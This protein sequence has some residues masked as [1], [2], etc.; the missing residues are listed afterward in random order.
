MPAVRPFPEKHRETI[1]SLKKRLSE[2]LD[3][4]SE[5]SL[6]DLRTAIRRADASVSALPRTFRERRKT[7]RLSVKL[8]D[9]MRRSAKVRDLDT[10]RA[11]LSAYPTSTAHSRLLRRIEK[12]R[13]RRLRLTRDSAASIR[14]LSSLCPD[15]K[16]FADKEGLSKRLEKVVKKLNARVNRML[17]VVLA[18]PDD[19]KALH[20]LR[21]DCKRMR[22]TLELTPVQGENPRLLKTLIS[23]QDL[24][25]SVRDGDVVIGY[26]EGLERSSTIDEILR[27]ERSRRKHDY[28]AFV[29]ACTGLSP[30]IHE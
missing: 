7:R 30:P 12:D 2:F 14:K 19:T 13:R 6:H 5:K 20:S 17:P 21:K 11:R 1:G 8:E 16:E 25:G 4:P 29:A 23:W 18:N 24:L 26:L 9:L 22:Y 27:A 3:E 15:A 10:V 28:D